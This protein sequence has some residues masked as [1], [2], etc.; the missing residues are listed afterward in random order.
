MNAASYSTAGR[1]PSP[2]YLFHLAI[3]IAGIAFIAFSLGGELRIRSGLNAADALNHEGAVAFAFALSL[4]YVFRLIFWAKVPATYQALVRT[5]LSAILCAEVV[6]SAIAAFLLATQGD[7]RPTGGDG[8]T[9]MVTIFTAIGV[10][11][12]ISTIIWLVRYRRE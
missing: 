4:G 1:R 6:F 12:Q 10:L 3:A 7:I 5:L 8:A 11:C 2:W 9:I